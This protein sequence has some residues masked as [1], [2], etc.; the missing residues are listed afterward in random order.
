MRVR[1]LPALALLGLL[2]AALPARAG[3]K[4]GKPPMVVVRFA[5]IET[6][7]DNAKYLAKLVGKEE[8]GRQLE[9]I[10]KAKTG[11]KGLEGID[12]RRPLG[13]YTKVGND[14]SDVQA[15]LMVPISDEKGFLSLLENVNFPAK[16]GAD[17]VYTIENAGPIPVPLDF[18]FAHKYAYFTAI[19][20]DAISKANVM[21]PALVFPEK[22]KSMASATIRLDQIPD[23]AK[24]IALAQLDDAL[25]REKEKM[26]LGET[27]TQRALREKALDHIGAHMG[28][29]I[30]EGRRLTAHLN[31]D[32]TTKQ[33]TA[34]LEISATSGSKLAK[35]FAELSKAKSRFAGLVRDDNAASGLARAAVPPDL[36]EQFAAAIKDAVKQGLAK[37]PDDAK[38]PHAQQ[39]LKALEPTLKAG[40]VDAAFSVR[41]PSADKKYTV[42]AGF[43]LKDGL[44]VEKTLRELLKDVPPAERALIK[45]DA[46]TLGGVKIHRIDAQRKFD[47]QARNLFGDNPIFVA[48]RPDAVLVTVGENGQQ[49]IKEAVAAEAKAA[50]PLQLHF[51]VARLAP[52]FA[53]T[54]EQKDVVSKVF[55]SGDPGNVRVTLEGGSALRLRF[56]ADLSILRFMTEAY[57]TLRSAARPALD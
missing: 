45:L 39:V 14:L 7:F 51:A 35:E 30:K 19:N 41:G 55:G 10:L 20:I 29:L 23:T 34:D 52:A 47:A 42:V 18:R 40:E 54:Q 13:F 38:R 46:E 48:F 5:S 3:D 53:K 56:A 44:E 33:L 57:F 25:G 22:D 49:A 2:V 31:I 26:P 15:V 50:V 8:F 16:K 6:V 1:W 9:G 28:A 11:P 27:P 32:R 21:P 43:G 36:R 12:P 4:Q 37:E 24:R 17:D